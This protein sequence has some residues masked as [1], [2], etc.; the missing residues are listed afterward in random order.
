MV[1]G[2][3]GPGPPPALSA[4]A[5]ARGLAVRPGLPHSMALEGRAPHTRSHGRN[6]GCSQR[7]NTPA[8]LDGPRVCVL[9]SNMV[10]MQG[11]IWAVIF[12]Y[13]Q[14]LR[15]R[16]DLRTCPLSRTDVPRHA[17]VPLLQPG[18]LGGGDA[19]HTACPVGLEGVVAG[20]GGPLCSWLWLTRGPCRF[21]MPAPDLEGNC[22]TPRGPVCTLT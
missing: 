11:E 1:A 4:G 18:W 7:Q 14:V 2:G 13:V 17:G 3:R 20:L 5:P 12:G 15:L 21:T 22:Y 10:P 9:P 16:A 8:V 19:L 6:R